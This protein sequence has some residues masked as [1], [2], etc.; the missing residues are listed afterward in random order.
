MDNSKSEIFS[1]TLIKTYPKLIGLILLVLLILVVGLALKLFMGEAKVPGYYEP[2]ENKTEAQKESVTHTEVSNQSI[3]NQQNQA[4]KKTRLK[5]A[6]QT[7]ST[8][9]KELIDSSKNETD[10]KYENSGHGTQ[11]N[12]E[13]NEAPINIHQEMPPR[14]LTQEIKNDLLNILPDKDEVIDVKSPLGD[15]ES[16][17]FA[18]SIEEYL[19]S[20]GYKNAI[21]SQVVSSKP[22]FDIT[23]WRDSNS[24]TL[25]I[26][27]K[28]R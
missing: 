3:H 12:I 15:S 26:G 10:R 13:K 6:H 28:R 17:S 14:E 4:E 9:K 16:R 18:K 22:F 5:E 2:I 8:P 19:H 7:I 21:G 11:I 25:R 27:P 24:I 1:T 20:M 23:Y